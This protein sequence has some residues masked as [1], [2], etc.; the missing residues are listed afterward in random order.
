MKK[1]RSIYDLTL[2][3]IKFT[4]QKLESFFVHEI[5]LKSIFKKAGNP[6]VIRCLAQPDTHVAYMDKQAVGVFLE[7]AK[8]YKP[9]VHIIM[10]DF[11]D[12]EGISH[13]PNDSMKPRRFIPEVIQAR[14]LLELT[15]KLTKDCNTRLFLT[16]N[17]CDWLRQSMAAQ[18]PEL[19]DGLEQLGMQPTIE[20]LLN[21][22]ALGYQIFPLNHFVRIGKANFTHGIYTTDNHPKKHLDVIKQ[23]IYYGHLH[24]VKSYN[25]STMDGPIE[26]ASLGCLCRLDAK[27]LKGKPNNWVHAFGIF[28]FFPDG[29]YTFLCPKIIKGKMSYAGKTFTGSV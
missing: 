6:E 1:K 12:A 28:E 19:F 27:F 16:G 24:D 14:K 13:W 18:L 7:F 11:L 29:N 8:F 23:N 26:A 25:S 3:D 9:H 15:V 22:K 20:S 10:G 4:S 17:H 5:D 2:P 21:L